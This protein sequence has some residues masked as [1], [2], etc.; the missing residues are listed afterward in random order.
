M[1]NEKNDVNPPAAGAPTDDRSEARELLRKWDSGETIWT[2]EMGGLGPGYEQA[3]QV[4]A[5][6]ILRDNIDSPL[7][8]NEDFRE[9]GNST[10]T[11]IDYELPDGS[12]SC[13]GYSGAQVGAA[14]Q[15]AFRW[16]R[17]GTA[18][19]HESVPDD[20]RIQIS[21]FWPKAPSAALPPQG[22]PTEKGGPNA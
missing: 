13:G 14:K 7:P 17:D 19:F 18:K 10:I 12:W 15:V 8:T 2:I 22:G 20:R 11:R 4:L 1:K 3:I 5:V 9:W 6:E 16:L 21:K